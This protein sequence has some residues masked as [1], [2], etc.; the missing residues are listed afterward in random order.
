MRS[1]LFVG[2]ALAAAGA[3]AAQATIITHNYDTQVTTST[4]SPSGV[5]VVTWDDGGGSGTVTLT[6]DLNP[7]SSA[8]FIT[9]FWFNFAG[10]GVTPLTITR[11]GGTG[12]A[13]GFITINPIVA[14]GYNSAG[15]NGLF[16][17]LI[18]FDSSNAGGGVRRFNFDETLVFTITGAGIT[19]NDFNV[20]SAVGGGGS[21]TQLGQMHIQG[22]A[23]GGSVHVSP[24]DPHDVPE[25]AAVGLLGLGLLAVAARRRRLAR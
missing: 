12:P 2:A 1:M 10:A 23:D 22:L 24:G 13:A 9:S 8:E 21:D 11:T 25:P 3:S 17:G 5:P 16:D 4:S 20:F 14:N 19:A 18:E 7:L 15:P 6:I